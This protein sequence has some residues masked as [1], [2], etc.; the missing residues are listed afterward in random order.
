MG[1]LIRTEELDLSTIDTRQ[2]R[3]IYN[4]LDCCLTREVWN[5]TEPLLDPNTRLIYNFELA[6]RA[7]AL[8]MMLQGVLID[9]HA[10]GQAIQELIHKRGRVRY[11]IDTLATVIWG[12]GLN[13]NSPKQVAD[14]FYGVMHIPPVYKFDKGK[15]KVDTGR[16][17]MEKLQAYFYAGPVARAILAHRD[18]GK[19]IST[20]QSGVDDDGRMRASYNPSA[21]ETGRWSSSRNVFGGGTN[22]QTI[23]ERLRYVFVASAG[24]KLAYIDLEQAESRIVGLLCWL[25]FDDARYLDACEAGDLH[26]TVCMMV[27]PEMEW[28][29]GNDREVADQTFYRHFSRR[30]ISK[31]AGHASNYRGMATTV[32][33][34]LNVPVL[35]MQKFQHQYFRAFP[36]LPRWHSWVARELQ[37]KRQLTTPLG[38]TRTFFGRARDDSTIR[39]AIANTPQSTVGDL[40]NLGLWRV[41]DKMNG[42]VRLLAQVHDAILIEFPEENENEI[43]PQVQQELEIPLSYALAPGEPP[44]SITVPSEIQVGW[45]WQ[46]A[47]ASN[48]DGLKVWSGNDDRTR[49]IEPTCSLLHRRLY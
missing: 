35:V 44:R 14:F 39:E 41:W 28:G 9:K 10:R 49:Q 13:P 47:S 40:L 34:L 36:G 4:A 33:G 8:E 19:Q 22:L 42:R 26:T 25:L 32:A 3:Q 17:A 16:G 37:I 27:W 5:K 30:D 18:L 24:F 7:P 38:R 46:H 20:L 43:L 48:L 23:T 1:I 21:T 15:R 11:I 31:R 29:R 2:Q 12:S 45:N 6:M